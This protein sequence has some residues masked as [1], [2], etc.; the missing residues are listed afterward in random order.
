MSAP[1]RTSYD[2][3]RTPV[4]VGGDRL[5]TIAVNNDLGSGMQVALKDLEIRGAGNMLGAEQGATS[6]VSVSTC[7]CG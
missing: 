7:T 4:R 5:Q 6:P 3:E 2:E 1:T